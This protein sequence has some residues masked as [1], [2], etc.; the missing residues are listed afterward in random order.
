MV[1]PALECDPP[2]IPLMNK[3]LRWS[4]RCAL[5]SQLSETF[6]RAAPG[7]PLP[8]NHYSVFSGASRQSLALSE[9]VQI[10]ME[11]QNFLQRCL[12]LAAKIRKQKQS[13]DP[14][15][16]RKMNGTKPR[17]LFSLCLI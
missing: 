5:L 7:A 2:D 4:R 17:I 11:V 10:A 15:R 6:C 13:F 12:T 16:N 3:Y 14:F 1:E 9:N 8:G